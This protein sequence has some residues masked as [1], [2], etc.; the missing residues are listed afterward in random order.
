MIAS[1][2]VGASGRGR[3]SS[4]RWWRGCW[5]GRRRSAGSGLRRWIT[6]LRWRLPRRVTLLARRVALMLGRIAC[7]LGR[8]A[9]LLR[10]VA[11][12]LRVALL[13]R[14]TLLL[15][16]IPLADSRWCSLRLLDVRARVCGAGNRHRAGR[17][18]RASQSWR[19]VLDVVGAAL[20]RLVAQVVQRVFDQVLVGDHPAAE[21]AAAAACQVADRAASRRRWFTRRRN[22]RSRWSD[23]RG[24][25]SEAATD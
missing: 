14:V 21:A 1:A 20:G 10:R 9:R 23:V 7:L 16:W 4:A 22:L 13:R 6:L 15:W 12:L 3:R 5:C 2:D 19:I 18:V 8:I 25:T 17:S 11:L 24:A